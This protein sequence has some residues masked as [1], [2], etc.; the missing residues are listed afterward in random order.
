M[1]TKKISKK[2]FWESGWSS[3]PREI[4]SEEYIKIL[5][6][7]EVLTYVSLC[8]FAD[9]CGY[10]FP[11]I[12]KIGELAR[13][14]KSSVIRALK[15]LES[16]N[17]IKIYRGEVLNGRSNANKYQLNIPQDW[18]KKSV[19]P[20]RYQCQREPK[21]KERGA[22]GAPR[23]VS[24]VHPNKTHGTRSTLKGTP[25]ASADPIPTSKKPLSNL[26]EKNE[27]E[28]IKNLAK[29]FK[30]DYVFQDKMVE[31]LKRHTGVKRL[32]QTI[33]INKSQINNVVRYRMIP[34]FYEA[35]GRM[36]TEIEVVDGFDKILTNA[37][38]FHLENIKSFAYIY[39]N[40]HTILQN[41]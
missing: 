23:V 7:K 41:D 10:L 25:P 9:E 15:C 18:K 16:H 5:S 36:P 8:Y 6:A 31:I 12:N 14:S 38:A 1:P 17:I 33:K 28:A 37:N 29:A 2:V 20:K 27:D 19:V 32:G 13:I 40:Y 3:F 39:R 22:R 21:K 4:F 34:D 30:I 35:E 26:L 24:E 11:S